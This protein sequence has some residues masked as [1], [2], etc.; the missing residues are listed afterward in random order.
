MSHPNLELVKLKRSVLKLKSEGDLINE[1]TSLLNQ[2][3]NVAAVCKDPEVVLYLCNLLE[4]NSYCGNK[5]ID[6]KA[7]AIKIIV[8]L[9]PSLNNNA[10]MDNIGALIDF[11]HSNKKIKKLSDLK[12]VASTAF[13]WIKKKLA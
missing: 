8:M 12:K 5:K 1:V 7:L 9:N 6:K 3:P 13:S 11:L 2:I 4:N 10:D